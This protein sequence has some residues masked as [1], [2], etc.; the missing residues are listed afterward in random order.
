MAQLLRLGASTGQNAWRLRRTVWNVL[1]I[2]VQKH[3]EDN[4]NLRDIFLKWRL[5]VA[6]SRE[7]GTRRD[8][9]PIRWGHARCSGH[10]TA[11]QKQRRQTQ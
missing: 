7:Y 4:A 6:S 1:D 11:K 5:T 9:L 2:D 8:E 3:E 10:M